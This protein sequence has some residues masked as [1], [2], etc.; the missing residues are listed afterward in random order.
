MTKKYCQLV[1]GQPVKFRSITL[2][3][4]LV[5]LSF[6]LTGCAPQIVASKQTPRQEK[7]EKIKQALTAV[8]GLKFTGEIPIVF[9][10]EEVIK[11]QLQADLLQNYGEEKLK[12]LSLAYGKLGLFP[13]SM[14]L[15]GSLLSF[16]GGR[17]AGTYDPKLKKVMLAG[18]PARPGIILRETALDDIVLVHEL[19]HALQDQNF[20]LGARLAPSN[21]NDKALALRAISEGDAILSEFTYRFG[22]VD[23]RSPAE[24]E[25]SLQ[26]TF[27]QLRSVLPQRPVAIRERILFQYKAGAFF[28][29]RVF[30]EKGW[31]GINRLYDSPPTSTKQVLHPEKYLD[32][33]YLPTE[34]ELK[35]LSGL[36][37]PDW[38]KIESNTLGELMVRCLFKRFFTQEEAETVANAWEGD[39]F[40]A[41]RRGNEVS[42]IWATVWDSS[43]DADEFS[44]AYRQLLSR[45]N[46]ASQDANSYAYV[47]RRGQ[48]VVVV[49]GLEGAHVKDHIEKVWQ[50]MELKEERP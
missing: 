34:L 21:N 3:V 6:S 50:E 38:Q 32:Q 22:G 11:K 16:Y 2:S 44:R 49:E 14:D 39:R 31:L 26:E 45:K 33:A 23:Q 17:V 40:V 5:I 1:F 9:E 4:F 25:Q 13:K 12:D 30:K 20:S 19:T 46:S 10:K 41:F 37:P 7:I 28:V 8:R 27:E 42:F 35:G 18:E 24:I 47:E 29:H 43:N 48:R 36:F 15:K